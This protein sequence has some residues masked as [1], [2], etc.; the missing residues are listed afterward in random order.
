MI[1]YGINSFTKLFNFSTFKNSLEWLQNCVQF[2]SR[3]FSHTCHVTRINLASQTLHVYSNSIDLY[4]TLNSKDYESCKSF[5]CKDNLAVKYVYY[6][7]GLKTFDGR[8]MQHI[9]FY[10]QI[11]SNQMEII[12]LFCHRYYFNISQIQYHIVKVLMFGMIQK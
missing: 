9:E 6:F 8:D 2:Y 1:F 12:N 10:C 3:Q 11:K 4:F 5:P 7:Y